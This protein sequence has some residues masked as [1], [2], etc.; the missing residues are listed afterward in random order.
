MSE[1]FRSGAFAQQCFSV[2]PLS[3]A[4]KRVEAQARL[5]VSCR[6][7]KM[8]H[9]LTFHSVGF[10][11]S[12]VAQQPAAQSG[13]D[14][15]TA[16]VSSHPAAVSVREMDV[17]QDAVVLRCADCRRLYDLGISTFETHQR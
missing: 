15:L 12:A 11:E 9:H 17:F 5:V 16:C 8:L 14:A 1:V 2:H 4:V 13:A 3:L 10:R 6:S 7:C